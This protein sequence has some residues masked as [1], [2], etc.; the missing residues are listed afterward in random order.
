MCLTN[1][2]FFDKA[3]LQ[4]G[5]GKLLTLEMPWTFILCLRKSTP[6]LNR[7]SH[8]SIVHKKGRYPVWLRLC[9]SRL[10]WDLNVRLHPSCWQE[11]GFSPVCLYVCNFNV[12]FDLNAASQITHL[13]SRIFKWIERWWLCC[14][15]L[16]T[17]DKLH[18]LHMTRPSCG[19][20]TVF[21]WVSMCLFR[22]DVVEKCF[23]QVSKRHLYFFSEWMDFSW[24][25]NW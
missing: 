1:N 10:L 23:S 13:K 9:S 18:N 6:N 15:C 17:K 25:F 16:L 22:F 7:C 11:Y 12:I 21:W 5:H 2:A 20:T 3:T 8:P 19:S 14:E 4:I 24:F